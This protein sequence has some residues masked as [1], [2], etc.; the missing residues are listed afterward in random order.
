[1]ISDNGSNMK[2]TRQQLKGIVKECL[3]EILSEGL[4]S[5]QQSIN[6]SREF[7]APVQRRPELPQQTQMAA[8]RSV[9]SSTADKISFLPAREEI[10]NAPSRNPVAHT[11]MARSL[12]SDPVL[13]DI[14]AD[15]ARS[16]IHHKMNE[17]SARVDHEQMIASA[18]DTAAKIMLKS[19]PVDVFGESAGKW[20]ALAFSEKLP[21]RS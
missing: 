11:D 20:A 14:F 12:T 1:M 16:G 9:R 3:V 2:M 5:T 8:Q 10:R 19:D 7:A 18:G 15:T 21:G 4:T 13:A 6:E 17:S